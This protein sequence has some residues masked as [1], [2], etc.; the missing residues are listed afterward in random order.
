[1]GLPLLDCFLNV[2]GTALAQGAPLPV[3][4][5]AWMW[6]CGMNPDRWNPPTEGVGYDLSIELQAL[7]RELAT[8]AKLRE[9]VSILSDFDVKLDGRPNFPHTAGLM[10]T[11][12]GSLPVEDYTVPAPTLDTIIAAQ[13]GALTRFRS[14]ELSCTGNPNQSYSFGSQGRGQRARDFSNGRVR[15]R[16]R[17]G[18]R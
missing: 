6:G 8:G 4:F 17:P 12:T 3:R 10:G 2:N 9:H 7:D 18:V 11:L 13:I 5:G 1:M 15:A 16:V 14:L